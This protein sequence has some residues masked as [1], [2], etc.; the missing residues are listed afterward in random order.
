MNP[1]QHCQALVDRIFFR[2]FSWLR[3]SRE[4]I[5][6]KKHYNQWVRRDI[7]KSK[8]ELGMQSHLN[9][10]SRREVKSFVQKETGQ[11]KEV[12]EVRQVC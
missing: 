2:D 3:Y 6:H 1:E 12:K 11:G 5:L 7:L 4:L 8:F 10:L 9:I